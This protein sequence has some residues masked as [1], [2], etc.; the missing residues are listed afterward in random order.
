MDH[1][2][3]GYVTTGSYFTYKGVRY[4]KRTRVLFTEG[5]YKR[6]GEYINPTKSHSWAITCGYK[7]PYFR[8]F[9]SVSMENGKQVLHFGGRNLTL[10]VYHY[11]DIDPDRDIEKIITPVYYFTPKEMVKKRLNDGTWFCYVWW[12]TLVYALCLLISPLFQQWYLIWT[13]GLY[14]YLRICYIELSKGELH[15]GW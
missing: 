7:F 9:S 5:F 2:V 13:V 1:Y 12:Q 3:S 14:F 4:G 8:T 6:I 11:V 10:T 15:R